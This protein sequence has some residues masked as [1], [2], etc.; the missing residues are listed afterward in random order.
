MLKC[1][2]NYYNY[3]HI[4]FMYFNN[5]ITFEYASTYLLQFLSN[6]FNSVAISSSNLNL[7]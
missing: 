2:K 7:V 3:I 1:N 5:K 4:L 6:K